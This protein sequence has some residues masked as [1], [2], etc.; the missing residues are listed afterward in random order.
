MQLEQVELSEHSTQFVMVVLHEE[1]TPGAIMLK[2]TLHF[3]HLAQKF[4]IEPVSESI[5]SMNSA[6]GSISA[7]F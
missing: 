2:P 6:E 5:I 4:A 3:V 7:H 1:H